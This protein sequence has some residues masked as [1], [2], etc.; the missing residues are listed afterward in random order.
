MSEIPQFNCS[1]CLSVNLPVL[2]FVFSLDVFCPSIR[3]GGGRGRARPPSLSSQTV[4]VTLMETDA[5]GLS[6]YY[7][8]NYY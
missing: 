6:A 8:Y 7:N 4:T 2:L 1:F 3:V 5:K